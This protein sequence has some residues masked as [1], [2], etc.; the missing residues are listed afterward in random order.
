MAL[1]E[2]GDGDGDN[3]GILVDRAMSC[4]TVPRGFRYNPLVAVAV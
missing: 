3:V 1:D 4:R 2:D